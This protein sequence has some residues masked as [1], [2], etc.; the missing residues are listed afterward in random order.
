MGDVDHG[1]QRAGDGETTAQ[2]KLS[3]APFVYGMSVLCALTALV[4][5]MLMLKPVAHHHVGV[6]AEGSL[7]T[8][9]L[10]GFGGVFVLA[11]LRVPL[12][13][14]MGVVGFIGLGLLRGWDADRGRGR[15]GGLRNR[16]RLHA[17]A[18]CRCSS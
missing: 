3:I 11:L 10:L 9:A 12:A 8:A 14:A 18:W 2:L 5:L 4:H 16:L 17:V 7:V 6:E 13:F 1:R 15:P